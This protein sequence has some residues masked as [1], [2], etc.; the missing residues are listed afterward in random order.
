MSSITKNIVYYSVTNTLGDEKKDLNS[1]FSFLDFLKYTGVNDRDDQLLNYQEYLKSWEEYTNVSLVSINV[2][3][4]NQ[5]LAFL[6]EIKL[7]FLSNEERRYFDN[8]DL[9]NNE[10]L[11]VSL[12]FF[13]TKIKEIALYYKKKRDT[14]T[15][16]LEY[17]KRKGTPSGAERFIKEQVLDIF[18]GDDVA[19][20]VDFD[21]A[22]LN[23]LI[24]NIDISIERIYDTFNDYYDLSPLKSPSFYDVT[25]GARN[26]YFTSNTNTLSSSFYIDE[27]KA[28]SDIINEQGLTLKEIPGLFATF[29]TTD[30]S[31]MGKDKFIEHKNTNNRSDLNFNY[32]KDLAIDYLG[33]DMYY[34]S[35]NSSGEYK[36]DKLFDAAFPYRNLLNINNPAT[37]TVPGSAYKSE[38]E[39]G[40]YFKPAYKGILKM[41]TDFIN[42]LLEVDI[43]KDTVYAFPDPSRVGNVDGLG[44]VKRENPLTFNPSFDRFKTP[45]SSFGRF[46]PEVDSRDQ[47]MHSFNT[48]EQRLFKANNLSPLQGLET[49]NLSGSIT[50]E[51]GDIFGNKFYVVNV[52]DENNKNLADPSF[53]KTP[54]SRFNTEITALPTSTERSTITSKRNKEKKIQVYSLL[55]NSL[56]PIQEKFSTVFNRFSYDPILYNQLTSNSF[57]DIDIFKNVYFIRTLN[58]LIVDTIDYTDEGNFR[59]ETFVSTVK[60]FNKGIVVDQQNYSLSNI[61]NPVRFNNELL[62]IKINSDPSTTSSTNIKFFQFEIFKYDLNTKK[63]INLITSNTQ[64]QSYFQD[65]FTFNVGSNIVEISELKFSYNSKLNK[66]ICITN[67]RDLN[68]VSFLHI[69]IFD[70]TGN[71]LKIN[72]NYVITPD[73]FN[74]TLNFF[75]PDVIR[76]PS[77]QT[78]VG[79]VLT[80]FLLTQPKQ[81]ITYGA[82]R[83]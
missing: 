3:V 27:D 81:D 63:E 20:L 6:E 28:I 38:R 43:A 83:F 55:E 44:G 17:I 80:K 77:I 76:N 64:N 66:F 49:L 14:I 53:F 74:N 31:Y 23:S 1:P 10:Q 25:T 60:K 59:P 19:G 79:P 78:S 26:N 36:Y 61:S 47:T 72:N 4:R 45:S 52:T 15:G 37:V 57:Q 62:Y 9:N 34:V 69:L 42:T 22:G 51:V 8:I 5:F 30:L 7:V 39:V 33:T 75:S 21:Q 2:N 50:K 13:T 18:S 54:L 48:L 56:F 11:T 12:P 58:Y 65:N 35:S 73:N 40:L 32:Q 70:I 24:N 41:E 68:N 67:F 46:L 82:F 16:N 29:D 71:I